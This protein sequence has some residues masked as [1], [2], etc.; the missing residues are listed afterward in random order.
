VVVSTVTMPVVAVPANVR[1]T[2]LK[3]RVQLDAMVLRSP[4]SR[5]TVPLP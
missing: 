4:R 1:S 5:E 2:I 3:V